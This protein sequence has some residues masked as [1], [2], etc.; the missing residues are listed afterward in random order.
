M[1]RTVAV[2]NANVAPIVRVR[3]QNGH[4]SST[5]KSLRAGVASSVS[6]PIVVY[7]PASRL[8]MPRA[9]VKGSGP[10][11][12]G[13]GSHSREGKAL[14]PWL[15]RARSSLR[16]PAPFAPSAPTDATWQPGALCLARRIGSPSDGV[17]RLACP[18]AAA[19]LH[20][21]FLLGMCRDGG[22]V[23]FRMGRKHQLPS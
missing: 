14:R 21:P 2:K 6:E 15:G 1:S 22:L 10:A 5:S 20:H 13:N 7:Y 19:R 12:S 4:I 8:A 3:R 11:R 16:L 9:L 23:W 18:Q 17:S